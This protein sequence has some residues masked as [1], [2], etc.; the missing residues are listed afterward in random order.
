MTPALRHNDLIFI[1]K[2]K[3]IHV[4][5]IVVINIREL[6]FVVKRVH[7]VSK[8]YVRLKGDNLRLTSS[9]CDSDVFINLII[10]TVFLGVRTKTIIFFGHGIVVPIKLFLV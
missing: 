9:I 3:K 6:G 10:G 5:K 8:R 7:S 4:N 2:R 1:Y